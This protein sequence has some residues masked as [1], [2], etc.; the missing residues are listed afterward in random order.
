MK[1][2]SEVC[3][4]QELPISETDTADYQIRYFKVPNINFNATDFVELIAWQL[5]K[6]TE[7]PL[8]ANLSDEDLSNMVQNPTIM[9]IAKY[10][11]HTQAVERSMKLVTEVSMA[12]CGETS[13][14]GFI[15]TKIYSRQQKPNFN[16]KRDY[17][18]D[19]N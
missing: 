5:Y 3:I 2:G 17:I 19:T 15:R 9:E 6:L 14:D 1:S 7:L 8:L 18:L 10:P 12:V 13:K 16:T 11:C 4:L